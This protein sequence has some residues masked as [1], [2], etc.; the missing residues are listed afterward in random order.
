[1]VETSVNVVFFPGD[2]PAEFLVDLPVAGIKA[3][4]TDHFIMLFR[5][6]PDQTLNEFH[7]RNGFFHI[8]VILMPVVMKRDKLTVVLV[9]PGGGDDGTSK[10]APDILYNGLGVT[11][12]G[13]GIDI[14]AVF[15][16]PV[17][18]G[19]HFFKGRADLGFHF[20]EQGGTESVTEEGIVKMMYIPPE[21]MIAV[22]AFGNEA[23]DMRIPFKVSAK[24]VEDH[25]KT[26]SEVHG[27]ILL[28]EHAGD[29]AVHGMEQAVKEG[30]VLQEK[31]PDSGVYGKHTMPVRDIGEFKGHRGS[32]LHGVEIATGRA[33]TAVAAERDEFELTAVRTA[34]HCAARGRIA[35]V[36]HFF[37]VINDRLTRMQC[38]NHFFI[39]VSENI[40]KYAHGTIIKEKDTKRN[41]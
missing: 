5:D 11:I 32:A 3:A 18:A 22:A 38:I 39:M 26:G 31:I 4:I 15:V 29:N 36:D 7:D 40:L 21:P 33:E 14:E 6:M 25:D 9:D 20:I 1:M 24:G 17:T 37:H 2:G 10:I 27:F 16:L 12:I 34:E 30:T 8:C 13:L 35:A 23:V 28:E 19:F 41:P